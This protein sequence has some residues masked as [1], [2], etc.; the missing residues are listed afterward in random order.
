MGRLELH[1]FAKTDVTAAAELLAA[2]HAR[3]REAFPFLGSEW[4]EAGAW[5]ETLAE[6]METSR[7]AAAVQSGQLVGFMLAR[8]D[9]PDQ[10]S[11][12][13]RYGDP[14]AG[15]VPVEGHAVS[16]ESDAQAVYTELYAAIS[17]DWVR[18]GFFSHGIHVLADDTAAQHAL[19]NAGFGRK[20]VAGVRDLGPVRSPG[21]PLEVRAATPA[22]EADVHRF[23]RELDYY[24]SRPP[25]F[26]PVDA[27]TEI[28]ALRLQ[29]SLFENPNAAI[30]LAYQDGRA[31]GMTSMMPP[32]FITPSLR[33]DGLSYLYQGIV[34]EEAR[35]GGVGEA[36]LAAALGWASEH[37]STHVALHYHAANPTGGRFWRKHGFEAV[38]YAMTRFIDERVAWARDWR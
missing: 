30:F 37:G 18:G 1:D 14:R 16:P 35:G 33:F 20:F 5:H 17:E 9:L 38:Y 4:E 27:E 24:H 12:G 10:R 13:A 15:F 23:E 6:L 21:P 3:A 22:D 19:V 7:G 28:G 26:M 11:L 2:R 31:V 8:K 25:M 32:D 36:L 34:G 29:E